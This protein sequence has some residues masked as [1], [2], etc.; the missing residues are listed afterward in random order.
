MS[1]VLKQIRGAGYVFI[2]QLWTDTYITGG[3]SPYICFGGFLPII[4]PRLNTTILR[5][6]STITNNYNA[7]LHGRKPVKNSRLRRLEFMPSPDTSTKNAIQEFRLRLTF[8]HPVDSLVVSLAGLSAH[9]GDL[10]ILEQQETRLNSM[11]HNLSLC[12]R[13]HSKSI[14][15]SIA[16]VKY[17][18]RSA[19]FIWDPCSQLFS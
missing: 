18:V 6:L 4:P 12:R 8:V 14:H 16:K 13:K 5:E 7:V 2:P 11:L 19:K 15:I 1:V 17:G 9:Y 3:F 10:H